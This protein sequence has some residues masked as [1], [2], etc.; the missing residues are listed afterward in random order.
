MS[1]T[2]VIKGR[3]CDLNDYQ[4]MH[5]RER[6]EVKQESDDVVAWT[7]KAQ[8]MPKFTK[9]VRVRITWVEKDEARDIDNVAFAVKFVLDGLKKAGV[10]ADDSRKHVRGISYDF[11]DPDPKNPRIIVT[12]EEAC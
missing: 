2:F 4:R 9:P 12:L 1:A 8:R 3:F 7:A 11:P 6:H 5:W 10:I